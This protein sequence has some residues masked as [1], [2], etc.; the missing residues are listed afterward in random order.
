MEPRLKAEFWVRALLRRCGAAD[1]P[2]MIVRRGEA[3]AGAVLV[4]LNAFENGA[5]VLAAGWAADGGRVWRRAGSA[6][7]VQPREGGPRARKPAACAASCQP[8]G[9]AHASGVCG[10]TTQ[11]CGA[12]TARSACIS[13]S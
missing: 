2:A 3:E 8:G 4:K 1:V 9:V 6:R 13:W 10:A 12:S 7:R 5:S 11:T